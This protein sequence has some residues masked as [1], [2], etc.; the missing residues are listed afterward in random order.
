[1]KTR[2]VTPDEALAIATRE[3]G[4]FFDRKAAALSGKKLQKVAVA[5]ANADGGEVYVGIADD[6]DQPDPS[7]RWN[8]FVDIESLNGLLQ[9]VFILAPS[10]DARYEVLSS[11]YPGYVLRIAVEKTAQVHKTSDGTVY[12]RHGA[13]SLPI[14]DAQK[15]VELSFAKGASSFEDQK[16][17][18]VKAE[19]VVDS[20]K[21]K[22][23]LEGYS[24][25]T[26][27]LD[28]ASN[29]NLLDPDTWSPRVA[30]VLLFA[31]NPAAAMPTKCSAKIVRYETKEDEPERDHLKLVVPLEG[32][33]YDLIHQTTQ[34]VSEIMSGIKVWTPTGLE[35]AEYPPEAIWEIIVN[36]F[37]HRDYSIYDDVQIRIFDD[38]IEILSP[39]KLPGYVKVENILDAR[40]SRNPKI[41]RTLNWYP[42]PPNKDLGEGLNTAYQRMKEF[43][44]KPPEITEEGNFVKVVLP[45]TPL[46]TPSEAILRFL[47]SNL[48]ITNS[49]A[50]DITGIRSENQVKREFYKLR[51]QGY[52]E[53]VVG[54]EGSN[55]AWQLT[56]KG[57]EYV[58]SIE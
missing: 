9:S 57:T 22:E 19:T 52:I 38:R 37:I 4:H 46:A 54:L 29:Q 17:G 13:Q 20:I 5:F 42:D 51:D 14:S 44:L 43:G 24:P 23:F 2:I 56:Q 3:E 8:G 18:S 45:H 27:P 39:G 10:L 12:V 47:S 16:L 21:I 28:Y 1:V 55:S 15:L 49:Q 11:K 40:F 50:R 31:T 35:T 41:V 48:Q 58:I 6:A 30:A 7:L 34:K 26:D 25:R 36:A 53:R 33:L 32:P